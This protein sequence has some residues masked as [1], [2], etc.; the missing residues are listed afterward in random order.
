MLILDS[1]NMF[2]ILGLYVMYLL[3]YN[4]IADYQTEIELIRIKEQ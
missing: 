4:K 2:T 3:D 1:Q